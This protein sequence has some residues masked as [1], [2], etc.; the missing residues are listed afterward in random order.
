MH[1]K[2]LIVDDE[3][4]NLKALQQILKDEPYELFFAKDSHTAIQIAKQSQPDLI[5]LDIMMPEVSGLETCKLLKD[6]PLTQKI[7]VIFITAL[8]ETEDEAK[9]FEVGGVDYINKPVKPAIVKAR[10]KNQ[11]A[12]VDIDEL[13]KT[14]LEIIACLGRAAE[15][16]D[17]DTGH[18]VSRMSHYTKILALAAG[19]S[20]DRAELLL[21]AVPMHDVGKIGIPDAILLKPGALTPTEYDVM[22]THV[23]IGVKII[24]DNPAELFKLARSVAQFHH[25]K[26]DGTGYPYGLK[27]EA[28][29]LEARIAAIADVFDALSN[30]RPYKSAW[31]IDTTLAYMN[32]QR[33]KH[34]DPRLLDLFIAN[35]DKILQVK[36]SYDN[37]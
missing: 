14:Q 36:A 9:G 7:P 34:F 32:E 24:G 3:A 11:L 17:D 20:E 29:P 13:R 23:N 2:I 30:P 10:I 28:I 37:Q 18:H 5:L 26:W 19:F 35:M 15:Y 1:S 33:E 31:A 6:D 25:E 27:G 8:N 4:S 16:K 12:L 21:R 22:K